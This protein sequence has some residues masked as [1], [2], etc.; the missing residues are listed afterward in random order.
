MMHPLKESSNLFAHLDTIGQGAAGLGMALQAID[1]DR[2]EDHATFISSIGY[3]V[4]T[5]GNAVME[6]AFNGKGCAEKALHEL[7][8]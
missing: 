7:V 6:G 1:M 5:I 3:L 8:G 2:I 4:E